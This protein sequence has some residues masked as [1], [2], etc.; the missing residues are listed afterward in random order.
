MAAA[1][2][3]AAADGAFVSTSFVCGVTVLA[4]TVADFGV[5]V[6]G[7]RLVVLGSDFIWVVTCKFV[8]FYAAGLADSKGF[9]S[10]GLVDPAAA[11]ETGLAI[12]SDDPYLAVYRAPDKSESLLMD[13]L[14]AFMSV[15][16]TS[17]RENVE[18]VG[19]DLLLWFFNL[20]WSIWMSWSSWRWAPW[21]G[22]GFMQGQQLTHVSPIL[23]GD[24]HWFSLRCCIFTIFLRLWE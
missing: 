20:T 15:S 4:E 6:V 5:V 9:L 8:C 17:W 7:F 24:C 10:A 19:R 3:L 12:L 14:R 13:L 1:D 18:F 22:F 21:G 11:A 16:G 23:F 2:V